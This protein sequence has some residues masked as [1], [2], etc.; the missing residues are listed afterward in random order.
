MRQVLRWPKS[1]VV[2]SFPLILLCIP[3]TPD[4]SQAITASVG[5]PYHGRLVNGIPFPRQFSGYQLRDADRTYTTPEVIGAMLDA[6]DT[7]Q[8]QFPGTQN[9]YFGDF[10][11][12]NGGSM[13][14]HRSHQNGRDVDVGMY[15]KGNRTLDSFLHMNEENL[16]VPRTW[17][18]V[19]SLLCSQR[20]QYIFVDRRI[21]DL[22]YDYA[23][24]RGMDTGYLDR[25]FA[26]NRGAVI[27]HVRNHSDHIHIRFYTP[28]ST[29]AARVTELDDQKRAVIEMAQQSYLPKKVFY[30]AN[31]NE[32][33][34]D[35]LARS[36]GVQRSDLCRWNEL[37]G[38]EILSPGRSLVFYKR[39]F[40]FE[41]VHLAQSLQPDSV[42]ETS[43]Y[44]Y[45]A[46]RPASSTATD[47][48]STPRERSRDRAQ[49]RRDK[50]SSESIMFTYKAKR[51]DTVEKIARRNGIDAAVLARANGVRVGSTLTP[52]QK[53]RL[54]G[55]RVPAGSGSCEVTGKGKGARG[56]ST[57]TVARVSPKSP[58]AQSVARTASSKS[59]A[60]GSANGSVRAPASSASSS[61]NQAVA[62]GGKN[63]PAAG[64]DSAKT[65]VR[66]VVNVKFSGASPPK[67]SASGISSPNSQQI[68]PKASITSKPDKAAP[69]KL[70]SAGS[71]AV[72]VRKD[73]PGSKPTVVRAAAPAGIAK[74]PKA[75]NKKVN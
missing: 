70:S 33:N 72:E 73:A 3:L 51:G 56:S 34:L 71:K 32:K 9:L 67:A 75:S 8:K 31:G 68:P 46:L 28:W 13:G 52:G 54:V 36:F 42:P 37:R 65:A 63:A 14:G 59:A 10:S 5:Q 27:Q 30:Y 20:V 49:Q 4:P 74:N 22:L 24:N 47:A 45:A 40:E 69:T 39:G 16:D 44:Q 15:A 55:L 62:K 29:M 23:R 66:N 18:F 53:I 64:I 12:P 48:V 50:P 43:T 26:N 57:T 2:F 41:P 58:T 61:S 60:S 19:E 21:Q 25:L 7:V 11:L 35:A 17:A 1:M 6:I 38:N